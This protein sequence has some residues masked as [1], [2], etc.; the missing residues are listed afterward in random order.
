MNP[1]KLT[2]DFTLF[3]ITLLFGLIGVVILAVITG[4]YIGTHSPLQMTTVNGESMETTL[5]EN[6]FVI[7][8][9]NTTITEGD[10]IIIENH[11]CFEHQYV[12][13]R[14]IHITEH[15]YITQGD[16]NDVTDQ[17]M[18][19]CD[20]IEPEYVNSKIEYTISRP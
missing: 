1:Q 5:S 3:Q 6:D 2:Q 19:N 20:V 15:G 10:V 16:N 12:I 13:H 14:V 7:G 11:S 9:E 18:R 4:V 17:E 8:F